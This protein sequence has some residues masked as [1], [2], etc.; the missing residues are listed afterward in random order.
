M[1]LRNLT[2]MS[3]GFSVGMQPDGRRFVVAVVKGTFAFPDRGTRCVLAGEQAPLV[4]ADTFE[5]EPGASAPLQEIDFALRKLR[6][7]V[8]L[9]GSAHAPGARPAPK[10]PVALKVG[11]L[12]KQFQVVGPRAW[13]RGILTVQPGSPRPFTVMP[14]SYGNAF[15]GVDRTPEDPR[16]HQTYLENPVGVGFHASAATVADGAPLPSTEEIDRP[17]SRPD[18]RYAPMAF[19]PLGRSWA[20]RLPLAGT[21]DQ[22]WLDEVFPFLPADFDDAYHQAAP[23]DQ[24]MAFPRGGE[25]VVLLNLTPEGRAAFRLP[26]MTMRV[27]FVRRHHTRIETAPVLDTIHFEP[28]ARRLSLCWRA[29]APIRRD[30]FEIEEI[31]VSGQSNDLVRASASGAPRGEGR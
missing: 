30:L 28:D 27:T 6:C 18:E 4:E 26:D 12:Q 22:R 20:P 19:G 10:V 9:S 11:A 3:A 24:Q 15:G 7:D 16:K 8:L 25:E 17:V 21:Y 2:S 14:I 31:L 13:K 23:A 5:G 29:S 1:H